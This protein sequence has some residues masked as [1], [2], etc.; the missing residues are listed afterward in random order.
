M[1]YNKYEDTVFK[2]AMGIFQ[3]SA[4]DFF[5]FLVAEFMV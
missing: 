1:D 3:Q 2:K 4:V 5:N